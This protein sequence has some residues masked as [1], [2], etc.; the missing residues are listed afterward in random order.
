MSILT[1]LPPDWVTANGRR[2][3]IYTDFRVWLEFSRVLSGD[4]PPEEKLE[5]AFM[6]TLKEP[7]S[8]MS[9][10]T[11]IADAI[12]DFFACGKIGKA[13]KKAAPVLDYE[14]DAEYIFA[15]FL[16]Q[17]GIDLTKAEYMHWW[18]FQALLSCISDNTRLYSVIAWRSVDV[19]KIK[20]RERKKL[21]GRMQAKYALPKNRTEEIG[22]VLSEV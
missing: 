19:G 15:A 6:L 9:G 13:S 18:H 21:A 20:D 4:L 3:P 17:Y 16:Q 2:Y 14:A 22:E 10:G 12:L 11:E 1:D 7:S 5:A 8:A